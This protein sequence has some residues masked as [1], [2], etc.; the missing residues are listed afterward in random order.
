MRS[1]ARQ[2]YQSTPKAEAWRHRA[3]SGGA[4]YLSAAVVSEADVL[5]IGLDGASVGDRELSASDASEADELAIG[6]DGA[7]VG[8]SR[9]HERNLPEAWRH[10]ALSVSVVSEA[11]ELAIGRDGASVPASRRHGKPTDSQE[12]KHVLREEFT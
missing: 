3:L 1:A 4:R 11:D 6:L 2:H 7:S 12:R 5:A 8:K 10:R 9:R